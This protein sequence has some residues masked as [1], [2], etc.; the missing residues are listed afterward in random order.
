MDFLEGGVLIGGLKIWT[1]SDDAEV[2]I[3]NAILRVGTIVHRLPTG[4][5]LVGIWGARGYEEIAEV[6]W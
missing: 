4:P 3:S 5:M 1:L 2:H 6:L